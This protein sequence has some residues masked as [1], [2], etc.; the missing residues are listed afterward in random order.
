M[1]ARLLALLPALVTLFVS[2]SLLAWL[3]WQAAEGHWAFPL[4]DTYIHLA[5]ARTWAE[6]GTWGLAPGQFNFASSAPGYT[7]L[8]GLLFRLDQARLAWPL[9]LNALAALGWLVW[10]GRT[11][12]RPRWLLPLFVLLLPLPLL[13]LLGMEHSLHLWAMT[14]LLAQLVPQGRQGVGLV[15]LAAVAAALRYESLLLI[16]WGS[17]LLAYRRQWRHALLLLMGGGL[18]PLAFGLWSR[19][20]G[21]PWLP[22]PVTSKGHNP[23][24]EGWGRWLMAAV[25][26]LYDN[27]YLLVLLLGLG[28]LLLWQRHRG[29]A[30]DS[31]PVLWVLLP[32]LLTSAHL[33]LAEVGGYRY[34]A[35][36]IGLALVGLA[37]SW[38]LDP[39]PLPRTGLLVGLL[40]LAGLPL[41][42][43]AGFFYRHYPRSVANIYQQPV[44]VGRFW[45]TA[46]PSAPLAVNDIGA[47]S[48]LGDGPVT[49]LVGVGD[50][51]VQ[52]AIRAGTFGPEAVAQLARARGFRVVVGHAHWIGDWIPPDWEVVGTWTI[53][54]NF[55]CAGP[56]VTWYAASPGTADTLRQRL[57]AYAPDLPAAVRQ[58]LRPTPSGSSA[59]AGP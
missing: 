56:A 21:G 58:D 53:P 15:L 51:A 10:V 19:A 25:E 26:R 6:H 22:L 16:G 3:G 48:Y 35:Y 55:I 40:L 41:L 34:E 7:L 5:L 50:Q 8:L 44:Q 12:D 27:P 28:A 45:A 37:R 2:T 11:L 30:W 59:P 17:L 31:A 39:P 14:V 57:Q 36:L 38:Q 20:Q 54:D 49:D 46:Y 9:L 52:A 47:V 29:H 23:L 42:V 13:L 1:P 18:A 32:L 33:L 43:R 24:H 4:D